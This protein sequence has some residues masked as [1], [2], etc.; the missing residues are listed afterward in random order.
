MILYLTLLTLSA[1]LYVIIR[2]VLPLKSKWYIKALLALAT[3]AAAGKFHLLYFIEGENFF[4]PVLP[5]GVIWGGSWLFCAVMCFSL[6]LLAADIVRL[7][8]YLLLWL[9][10]RKPAV[11]WHRLSM[12]TNVGMLI[13]SLA[14]TGWGTWCGVRAP[15][16]HHL[17]LELPVRAEDAAPVRLVQ[18][19]DLHADSTK[20]ADFYRDIVRRTNELAPDIV[21]ITGDFADGTVQDCGYALQP[22]AELNAPMGIF[23]VTGNHDY[24]WNRDGKNWTDYLSGLGL[25]FIDDQAHELCLPAGD[26][27][28][29]RLLLLGARDPM[30]HRTGRPPLPLTE[31]CRN[32]SSPSPSVLLAHQPGIA[33]EAADLGVELQL[34]GHTHGG[35]FPGLQSL[36][37]RKNRGY[38]HGLYR[39]GNMQLYVSAGTSLWT[40]VCMRLG[41]PSEITL[42]DIIPVKAGAQ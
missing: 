19:T 23:A 42:I 32:A 4:S 29:K 22:L 26:G 5:A 18:L 11:R 35:Q 33:P 27:K 24:F 39:V 3:V 9:L 15:E 13:L 30:S 17:T 2:A 31:L 40:P 37:A 7:P 28:F 25:R 14:L 12:L 10:H 36:V 20:D 21:V 16:V 6:L 1:A 34:S 41:V 8:L 38:V